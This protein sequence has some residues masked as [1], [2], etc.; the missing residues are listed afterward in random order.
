M[1]CEKPRLLGPHYNGDPGG[2]GVVAERDG[3]RWAGEAQ[4][5]QELLEEYEQVKSIVSTLES[6]KVDKPP[7]FPVS[8]QDEPFR[9]PA[10]WPPPVPAE[11]RGPEFVLVKE[12]AN[13]CYALAFH[14]LMVVTVTGSIVAIANSQSLA[15]GRLASAAGLHQALCTPDGMRE[16]TAHLLIV[17]G[18]RSCDLKNW[19]LGLDQCRTPSTKKNVAPP[20]IRR[21]NR[22]VRP[23]RKD[24]GAGARGLV[25]RAHPISKSDKPASRDKDCRARG[26]DDKARLPFGRKNV[27]DSASDGEIPKFDGAGYDK[28]LVEALERDIVSRNPSIHWDDIADL[29]EAKKLLREAVVL[30]M[31]MPDFFKGIRRPWKGVLMVGPPGTGKTMLAKAV[32]TE[33]GTTFFNVSSSTLTSKYRGESEKLVRLLFEMARFYAPTTIFIDEIDSICSRR[34]TSDE[35]EASRRVKSELLVQMDGVG[36]ALENDD[37]SKMVMVLAATNFPWDIDEAL[38]RRLEKRIYIPLPTAK[39]RAELLKISLREVELDPDIRL[40]DIADK[41]E[42]YSGADITNVCRDASLMA[43]RRR[44]S[45]LSPEEIR[46]LSKE[47]LQMPVTRGDFELALK[48]IAK[49]VSAADLEKYEKWMV[50]FGSA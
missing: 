48:K 29:E 39:G 45:G 2:F 24:M 32:A 33:C 30:P 26:R 5:R 4:V 9:D 34:G 11:H 8:C 17:H 25:G 41:I 15:S 36:G 40:E 14:G 44:I 10:V 18:P 20:Q 35:H 28:D 42:G 19:G 43:M 12:E 49:S 16:W 27:Q 46:A 1:P 31:W 23:L 50:E 6:F 47:E 7:D 37:P 38:R 22:E 3:V 21:P 13:P